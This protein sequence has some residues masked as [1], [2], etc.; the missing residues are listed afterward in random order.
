MMDK[1]NARVTELADEMAALLAEAREA[2]ERGHEFSARELRVRFEQLK[3]IN[4]D[5]GQVQFEFTN[6][7]IWPLQDGPDRQDFL[8]FINDPIKGWQMIEEALS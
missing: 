1:Y 6:D 2:E 8:G 3:R 7:P 5:L 4:G